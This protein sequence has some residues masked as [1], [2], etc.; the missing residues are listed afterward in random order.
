[1]TGR[2]R[3]KICG[4][5]D[6]AGAQAAVVAGAD[7]VGFVF[8]ES[9][10]RVDIERAVSIAATIP[11]FVA[12]VA[13]FHHP[14]PQDVLDVVDAL[15]P[16]LVQTELDDRLVEALAGRIRLLPVVHD[17]PHLERDVSYV[18]GAI[19]DSTPMLLEAAGRGGRGVALDYERAAALA[20][21]LPL[22]LAGGLRPDNV[23]AAIATVRPYAVDVS[24]GV[25]S[26]PGAKDPDLVARFV[27]AASGRAAP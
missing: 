21:R 4:V 24:S 15:R 14:D 27:A 6:V 9:P 26:S 18:L 25:E 22:V 19:G 17:G 3:V 16:D 11:P 7:A 2:V 13:V 23:A 20:R 1:M 5:T 12:L 10:R 8:A